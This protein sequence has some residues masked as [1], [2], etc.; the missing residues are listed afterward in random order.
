[1]SDELGVERP[2]RQMRV[3]RP[4]GQV[5]ISYGE[6]RTV[7]ISAT[8]VWQEPPEEQVRGTP[9]L[10]FQTRQP[11]DKVEALLSS[12]PIPRQRVG[13]RFFLRDADGNFAEL[14][15]ASGG[16]SQTGRGAR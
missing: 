3:P 1:M 14:V 15:C 4:N 8:R 10:V 11:A 12:L 7:L 16:R 13:R 5:F 2:D 9:R 6:T